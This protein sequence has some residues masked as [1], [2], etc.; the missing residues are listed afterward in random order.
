MKPLQTLLCRTLWA[1]G[2]RDV[3][4]VEEGREQRQKEGKGKKAIERIYSDT[5]TK[6]QDN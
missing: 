5:E 2:P 4:Q 1:A 6:R 3:G